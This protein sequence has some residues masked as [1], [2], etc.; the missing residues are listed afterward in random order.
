M[1]PS[2]KRSSPRGPALGTMHID[3]RV[4]QVLAVGGTGADDDLLSTAQVA[5]W[6]GVSVQWLEVARMRGYGP[7][8]ELMGPRCIRYRRSTCRE[9]L[10]SRACVTTDEG[11]RMHTLD[12]RRAKAVISERRRKAKA[13]LGERTQAAETAQ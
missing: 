4:D 3:K 7:E 1:S 5:A 8:F 6:F 2:V 13:T 11:R 12:R 10:R 9:W